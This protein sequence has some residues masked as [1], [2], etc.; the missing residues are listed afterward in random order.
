M[1]SVCCSNS[2]LWL[3]RKALS[4]IANYLAFGFLFGSADF[5]FG[6]EP[7]V[8]FRAWLIASLEI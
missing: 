4:G 6:L 2:A 5:L 8:Y 3:G 7:I 1:R